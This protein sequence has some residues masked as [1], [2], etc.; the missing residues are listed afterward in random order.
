MTIETLVNT[1]RLSL[2]HPRDGLRVV[3]GW[4][5]SLRDSALALTL[6]AVLSAV[7]ISLIIGPMPPEL[8]PVSVAMLTNPVYLAAVQLLGL[9]M[10]SLCLHLL[11]RMTKGGGTFPEAVAM[12]AWLEALMIAISA[13]QS[14]ALLLVPPL[15]LL[16]VPAGMVFS[17]WLMTSFVA[18]L[19]GYTSMLMT[20]LGVA[21]SFVA[22]VFAMIFVLFLLFLFGVLH[23]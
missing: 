20:L 6:M 22:A 8:D 13:V 1:A 5:L 7:L 17:L 21:A 23:V 15:G 4:Q 12:M 18:E 16:L 2:R 11:G 19:H 10:I 9:G 14:I 3:L